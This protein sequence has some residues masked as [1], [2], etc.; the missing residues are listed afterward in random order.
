M[1]FKP[2]A[3]PP[4]GGY[5]T[6]E[7]RD[8]KSSKFWCV[9]K[10]G[11]RVIVSFGKIGT[12]GQ[13]SVKNFP[14]EDAAQAY[15]LTTYNSKLRKGYRPSREESKPQPARR[16]S[17]RVPRSANRKQLGT[18]YESFTKGPMPTGLASREWKSFPLRFDTHESIIA[19]ASYFSVIDDFMSD[20]GMSEF[21][22]E[23]DQHFPNYRGLAVC[24]N[25]VARARNPEFHFDSYAEFF[26]C[27]DISKEKRP[28]LLW[29][30][31][32]QFETL[33]RSFS[34]FHDSLREW[35]VE[36]A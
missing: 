24:A 35:P 27:V 15:V 14:N 1:G 3:T 30:G 16:R 7:F 29:T 20:M 12:E 8:E 10:L 9:S 11:S 23:F 4:E 19:A 2:I 36:N 25:A 26:L 6:L 32:C 28:V 5:P 33:F 13:T 22:E 21:D 17:P 31:E 18:S 34:A